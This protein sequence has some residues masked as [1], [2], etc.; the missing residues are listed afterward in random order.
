M[1]SKGNQIRGGA[2][3]T[4]ISLIITVIMGVVFT[5]WMIKSI[6]KGDYGLYTLAM[7]VINIFIFDFG[8]GGAVQRYMSKYLAEGEKEKMKT[9]LGI[10]YKL[11]LLIDVFIVLV[12]SV[13]Y[14]FL[15]DLYQGLSAEELVKFKTIYLTVAGFSVISF[16][17]VHMDGTIMAHERFI[18]LKMSDLIHKVFLVSSMTI[19]LLNGYGLYSLVVVNVFAGI[20][21][22]C[23]K[24]YILNKYTNL[25]VDWYCWDKTFLKEILS[26]SVWIMV[27]S[28][29]QRLI[30]SLAPS[31][32]A[33]Y[34]NTEEIAILGLAILIEGYFY[35]FAN[36]LNGL[37]LP[38][39]S[40]LLANE[41]IKYVEHLL[42]RVGRL[43]VVLSG[44][45]L[46]GLILFGNHFIHVWVGFEFSPAYLCAI[47]MITPSFFIL[48]QSIAHTTMIASNNVKYLAF[49]SLIMVTAGLAI[50]FTLAERMGAMGIAIGVSVAYFIASLNNLRYYRKLLGLRM[51]IFLRKSFVAFLPSLILSFAIGFILNFIFYEI[52]VF[53]LLFKVVLFVLIY[54]MITYSVGLKDSEKNEIHSIIKSI[55]H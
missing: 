8:L 38:R 31:I 36:A 52:T 23:I 53:N 13:V 18:E 6:G 33:S 22:L 44:M 54:G 9:F 21:R 20:L 10:V 49:S 47:V 16:P 42:F 28:I 12:L 26:F 11:Y 41:G 34:A 3:I 27:S 7:S 2:V 19:L 29:A 48:P 5:P 35:L 25:E 15:S 32:L 14:F 37:F 4:Y 50:F 45:I 51:N 46:L 1:Y 24:V 55:V 30:L 40:R 17:L 39:V 43:Q